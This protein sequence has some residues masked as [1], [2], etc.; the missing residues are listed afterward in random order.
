MQQSMHHLVRDQF[1]RN[2][3]WLSSISINEKINNLFQIKE[4]QTDFKNLIDRISLFVVV[5]VNINSI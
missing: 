4:K 1:L 3:G 2:L 5:L